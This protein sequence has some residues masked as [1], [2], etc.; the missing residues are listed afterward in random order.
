MQ[1]KWKVLIGVSAL[2]LIGGGVLASIK[3]SQRDIVTVQTGKVI[4]EDLASVVTASGEI[5]PRTYISIGAEYQGQITDIMVKE[6]DH[7]HKGQL[8]ARIDSAQS[9][10][11]VVAQ[12]AALDSA[13]AD[14]D[15]SKAS[16][17]ASEEGY[18]A[19]EENIA[20]LE[21]TL[22]RTKADLDRYDADFKRGEALYKDG[23]IPRSDYEQ[24]LALIAGQKAAMTEAETRIVQG[25]AQLKQLNAQFAGSQ[26]QFVGT[27]KKDRSG[28]GLSEP[29]HRHPEKA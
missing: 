7:V 22:A 28:R 20:T 8:L 24:R 9:A 1:G 29:Y 12:K 2:V 11:D 5:N 23:L 4:R 10:A 25:K 21:A 27:Q 16:A 3:Y 15:A 6:G 17:A 13:E 19:G 26:A 14:A 18:K